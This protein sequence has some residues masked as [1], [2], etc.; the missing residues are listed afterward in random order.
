M[1]VSL[2]P[3][4][5]KFLWSTEVVGHIGVHGSDIGLIGSVRASIGGILRD[6]YVPVLTGAETSP[7]GEIQIAFVSDVDVGSLDVTLR[8]IDKRGA[9]TSVC[10]HQRFGEP[11]IAAE[12]PV[13]ARI[14]AGQCKSET[15]F[16]HLMAIGHP[17]PEM[18]ESGVVGPVPAATYVLYL[19]MTR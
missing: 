13:D 15:G 11:F 1:D 14:S 9:P 10:F 17:A 18:V 19:P 7:G 5:P 8:G 16:Y 6:V 12:L 4:S 3:S 2:P